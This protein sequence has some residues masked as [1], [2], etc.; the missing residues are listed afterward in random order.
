MA[1]SSRI[2]LISIDQNPSLHNQKFQGSRSRCSPKE[3]R[4]TTVAS[5]WPTSWQSGV[6]TAAPIVQ[7]S[8]KRWWRLPG[9]L[10]VETLFLSMRWQGFDLGS[11]T[12]T[13][14]GFLVN[15]HHLR[16]ESLFLGF[17]ELSQEDSQ[18]KQM[19]ERRTPIFYE[20]SHTTQT[21]VSLDTGV[22]NILS[23]RLITDL[24]Q[25]S[26]NCSAATLIA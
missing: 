7:T 2:S 4:N 18:E 15:N 22:Q 16:I 20:R 26:H 23:V 24:I 17:L 25:Q 11:S 21:Q 9:L 8:N 14:V 1:P 13:V 3:V 5:P 10:H 12:H 19:F 6:P